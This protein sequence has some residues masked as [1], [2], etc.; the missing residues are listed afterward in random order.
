M[1]HKWNLE[2]DSKCHKT[3]LQGIFKK[4]IQLMVEFCEGYKNQYISCCGN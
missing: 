4:I 2:Y 1:G 3:C